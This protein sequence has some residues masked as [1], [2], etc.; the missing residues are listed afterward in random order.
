MFNK[1]SIIPSNKYFIY[2]F[3]IISIISCQGVFGVRT[4]AKNTRLPRFIEMIPILDIKKWI[5]IE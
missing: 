2:H 5:V 1:K 3:G 4:H